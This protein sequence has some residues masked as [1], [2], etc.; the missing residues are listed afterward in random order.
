MEQK[1][2]EDIKFARGFIE[3][4]YCTPKQCQTT[5]S[6]CCKLYTQ[7]WLSELKNPSA[8]NKYVEIRFKNTRKEIFE[9]YQ[10]FDLKVGDIVAVEALPGLDIGIVSAVDMIA[11]MQIRKYKLKK[12]S[13][14]KKVSRIARQSDIEKWKEAV[15]L[16]FSTLTQ[17]REIINSLNLNM[18]LSD[19]EYQGDKS[20]AIFYYIADERV[21]FRRLIKKMADQFK[22]KIE[23]KQIGARQEA[24]RVGGIGAC[25]RELCC[26]TWMTEFSSVSTNAARYQELA[27]NPQKLT[28]QCS[29]LK[30]CLNNE[31]EMY[32]ETRKQFP[33]NFSV[34]KIDIGDAVHI[35][36][37]IFKRLMHF[38]IK[39]NDV[40]VIRT[41]DI[42]KVKE[43]IQL[44]K[45]G[46]IPENIFEIEKPNVTQNMNFENSLNSDNI[47]RFANE[48]KKSKKHKKHKPHNQNNNNNQITNK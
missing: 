4:N 8:Q 6:S 16:E 19:V 44:N 2:I 26:T 22:I 20:K 15:E 46:I 7:D 33:K 38:E 13:E 45:Q 29:K 31:L 11:L 47:L 32:L 40:P 17:T 35:K 14:I 10:N 48:Q 30:C 27:L 5:I 43:I 28:G 3:E 21:D 12:L 37:D 24:G 34:L 1:N 36:N 25:G 23:M 42:D 9:N 39:I 41:L 18:K